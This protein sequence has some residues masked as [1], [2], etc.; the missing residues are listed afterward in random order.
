MHVIRLFLFTLLAGLM[1]VS[2]KPSFAQDMDVPVAG[3]W[4][5]PLK[6]PNGS[7][8]VVFHIDANEAGAL[9][10]TLDSPDQG[11]TGIPVTK[12]TFSENTLEM[13][14]AA[15]AGGFTGE[16]S[17][18]GQTLTGN[19]RQGGMALPL[20]LT[21]T[22]TPTTPNR[23]QEPQ[24]PY[25]YD[26]EEVFFENKAD[27]VKLAGTLTLPRLPGPHPAVVLVSGSG[28]Q[29]RNESLMGH[30]PFLVLADHLTRKGI[31]VL[32]YDDRGTAAS[33]GNFATATT[34][35][36]A[37][38]AQAAVDFLKS[39]SDID[40]TRIG[41]AGH[42][43]GGLI[44]PMLGA[45]QN[46]VAFVVLLAGPGL[47]GNEILKLQGKLIARA[48]GIPESLIEEITRVNGQ[49]YD[50]VIAA[51]DASAEELEQ[52]LKATIES[53]KAD[54]P[55][56]KATS[57]GLSEEREPQMIS[58]LTSPWLRYFI[59]YD[60]A[61]VLEKVNAPVL[62]IIGSKDL[63]VPAEANTESIR[64]ALSKAGQP[65]EAQI[66]ENLNHLFQTAETG[67]VT[68]Y[69]QIEETFSP[70]ALN[71]VSNWILEGCK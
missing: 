45:R 16:L 5:G 17:A 41:V 22:D 11:A 70:D 48:N 62:S 23:P 50:T 34:P 14:V 52:Q 35:D 24:Q 47:P 38:D 66:L 53:I 46:N 54:L 44:A 57:L 12:T 39:H 4:E 15:I 13:E 43:E 3:T 20:T 69:G 65:F 21:R 55:A 8:R 31:A 63:Q 61:P 60:P 18:D 32:R 25:P 1:V 58:Q 26:E 68:E 7:F 9:S 2:T 42:S 40:A 51:S 67:S 6:A 33:T 30:K 19:W 28:P 56:E 27:S 10:A 49:L 59:T 37:R 36:L 71:L 29:D 64:Q